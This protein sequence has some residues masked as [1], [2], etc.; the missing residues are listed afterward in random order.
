MMELEGLLVVA[1]LATGVAWSARGVPRAMELVF[2]RLDEIDVAL[3]GERLRR[4]F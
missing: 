1:I 2:H 3:R 4:P